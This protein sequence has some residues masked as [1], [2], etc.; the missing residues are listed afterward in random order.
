MLEVN[1]T[2][3]D[4]YSADTLTQ[5]DTNQKLKISGLNLSVVPTLLFTN[6]LSITAEPIPATMENGAIICDIPNGLLTEAYP[7]IVYIRVTQLGVTN[8]VG[9]IKIAV[10][11]AKKPDDYTFIDNIQLV[12]YSDIQAQIEDLSSEIQGFNVVS[13]F[14][15]GNEVVF[16]VPVNELRVSQYDTALSFGGV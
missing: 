7:I 8:T 13:V 11:P 10:I 1:F 3:Y 9:K 6:R 15:Y 2:N 12:T 16:G 4:T 14:Q 5:W